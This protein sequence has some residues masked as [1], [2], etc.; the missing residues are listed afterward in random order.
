M[1]IE[2]ND[3]ATSFSVRPA[4][5]ADS[6]QIVRILREFFYL[7]EPLN[8]YLLKKYGN[9]MGNGT[10]RQFSAGELADP[11]L[12]AVQDDGNVIGI[13]LN[14]ISIRGVDDSDLYK[15]EIEIRQKFLDFL[16]H[17]EDQSRFFDYFPGCEKGM[18]VDL[19]SVDNAFS[20]RGVGTALLKETG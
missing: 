13:C 6:E 1:S 7:E 18:T 9:Y 5:A 2:T 8:K 3:G 14:R 4:C 20:K 11:T 15:S 12:V 17:I 16:R 10:L 19:I